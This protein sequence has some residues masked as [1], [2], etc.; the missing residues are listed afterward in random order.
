MNAL[1]T[2]IQ[3]ARRPAHSPAPVD[4][5]ATTTAVVDAAAVVPAPVAGHRDLRTVPE[6]PAPVRDEPHAGDPCLERWPMSLAEQQAADACISGEDGFVELIEVT[7]SA[8]RATAV[9]D[10]RRYEIRMASVTARA[11]GVEHAVLAATGHHALGTPSYPRRWT[12]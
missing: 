9:L 4:G 7:G 5:G 10:R 3:F 6:W 12:S 2:L 8:A 11:F 1:R